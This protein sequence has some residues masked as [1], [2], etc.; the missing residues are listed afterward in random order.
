M[1]KRTTLG[2]AVINSVED[3]RGLFSVDASFVNRDGQFYEMYAEDPTD[4]PPFD[5]VIAETNWE[6]DLNKTI[7]TL[8]ERICNFDN[9]FV[10]FDYKVIEV[11]G[12]SVVSVVF[13][14]NEY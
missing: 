8:G 9:D 2:M 3:I 14:I 1:Y 11:N 6:K 12:E 5:E 13:T 7:Y 10:Y 4:I